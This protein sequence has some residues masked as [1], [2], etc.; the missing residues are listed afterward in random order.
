MGGSTSGDLSLDKLA[1][2]AK[3][4]QKRISKLIQSRPMSTN[5]DAPAR[6]LSIVAEPHTDHKKMTMV[7]KDIVVESTK[8]VDAEDLVV[9]VIPAY[10]DQDYLTEFGEPMTPFETFMA[11]LFHRKTWLYLGHFL[12]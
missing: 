7:G 10:H 12:A 9:E 1:D 6:P 11:Y 3:D 8:L 4:D 2:L 5:F